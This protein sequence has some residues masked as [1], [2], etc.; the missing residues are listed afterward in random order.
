MTNARLLLDV[1]LEPAIGTRFQPTGFPDIGAAEFERPVRNG[2]G[3][4][5]WERSL[6]VE[7]A[8][9]MANR[10]RERL[11]GRGHAEAGRGA[12]GCRMSNRRCPMA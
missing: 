3:V 9:S 8:Q 11:V 7:S 10:L 4:P 12:R 2:D 5:T 6:L 1:A